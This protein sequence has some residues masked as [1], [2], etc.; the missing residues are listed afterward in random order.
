[1]G[2]WGVCAPPPAPKKYKYYRVCHAL[3]LGSTL[4]L[5]PT[6]VNKT[7]PLPPCLPLQSDITELVNH[8][9]AEL[10]AKHAALQAAAAT[11]AKSQFLARMSHEISTPLNGMI[12]VGQ[13]LA[14]TPLSPAQVGR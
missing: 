6:F 2:G 11:E 8:R 7:C 12:A 9:Q 10:A 4:F 5:H 3:T 13:L 14:D 1:V